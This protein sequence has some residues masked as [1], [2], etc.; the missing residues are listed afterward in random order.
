MLLGLE[1]RGPPNARDP[2]AEARTGDPAA[3]D[4]DIEVSHAGPGYELES[5]A[6]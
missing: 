5:R 6:V 3:N 4:R 2:G 1:N